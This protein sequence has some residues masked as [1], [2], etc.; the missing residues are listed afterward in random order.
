MESPEK[1][2]EAFVLGSQY[3]MGSKGIVHTVYGNFAS[4]GAGV[5]G[6]STF[7]AYATDKMAERSVRTRKRS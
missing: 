3:A 2:D 4:S 6:A 1:L 5:A 7:C